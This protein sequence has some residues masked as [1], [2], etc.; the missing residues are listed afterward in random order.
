MPV[1]PFR[2]HIW[3]ADHIPEVGPGTPMTVDFATTFYFHPE[4]DGVLF[5][6]SDRGE[7]STFSTEVDEGFME[8]VVDAALHRLPALAQAGIRTSWA[9]LYE[10]TPDHQAILGPAA[11]AWSRYEAS[12]GDDRL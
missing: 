11:A 9:G 7:P 1:Q 6:M 12:A 10:T 8:R 5:G 3:V 4:G 2:R